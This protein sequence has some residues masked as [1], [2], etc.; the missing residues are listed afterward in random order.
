MFEKLLKP[1]QKTAYQGVNLECKST[2]KT[3]ISFGISWATIA[4]IVE[5]IRFQLF[6]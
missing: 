2:P 5:K 1:F 4:I 3:P 6:D